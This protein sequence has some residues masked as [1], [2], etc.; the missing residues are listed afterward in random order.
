MD[1]LFN[2][3]IEWKNY[4][5]NQIINIEQ[6]NVFKFS[7]D[8]VYDQIASIYTEALS[9]IELKKADRFLHFG[10]K[11]KFIVSKYMLRNLLSKLISTT[12]ASILFELTQHKK[13]AIKE[14][15]EFNIT[16]SNNIVLIAINKNPVG[17]DIEFINKDF[18]YES[19][20]PRVF[21]EP[22]QFYINSNNN[23][24]IYF[25]L[26]WTR[27]EALLKATGEGLLDHL[28][29]LFCLPEVIYRHQSKYHLSSFLVDDGY[30]ASVAYSPDTEILF[31]KY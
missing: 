29:E 24:L 27:K 17:L 12:P 14:K 6:L 15:V 20:M 22:E 10:D 5:Q 11:K 26:L 19:L 30:V 25:Y 9:E 4:Q 7:V 1:T 31:W 23:R 2:S 16:H 21:N 28:E 8:K 3:D 18:D 13:P